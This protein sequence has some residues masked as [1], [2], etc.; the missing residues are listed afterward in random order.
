MEAVNITE[1]IDRYPLGSFQIRIILL[2]VLVALLDGFDLLAIGAAAPAMMEPLRIATN[3]IG[4][5]FS[6]ALFG[7]MLGAFVLGPV[8]DRYGRRCVLISSTAAFGV[9]TL[10]T[11]IAGTLPQ[12]LLFR[13]FAGVGLGG[14]MPS[15]IS[16]AAEYTPRSNRQAVIGLMWTGFPLGGV[17][18][19][20][21]ASRLIDAV[22]WQ[23]LF[24]IGGIL[25]VGL[26]IV[27]IRALPDSIEFL[28]M[29]RAASQKIR[30]LLVR[31]RP[32]IHIATGCQFVIDGEKTRGVPVGHLFSAGRARGTVLLWASYFLTFMILATSG[33]W[34]PTLLQRAGIPGA[35][36]SVAVALFALGSVF[37]T[38]LA[39]FL[40]SRFAARHVL[41]TALIGSA[42]TF[43]ILGHAG[44]SLALVIVCLGLAGFFLGVASSGL[45]ALGPLLYSTAIRSTGVG[46][47]MGLGRLGGIVGPLAIGLLVSR[48]WPIG[49]SFAALA[50]PALCAALFTSL[51]AI[52]RLPGPAAADHAATGTGEGL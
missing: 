47:A 44:Q 20:F 15:F 35:R 16:L 30:D 42:V 25:P 33:A 9:F 1:L 51:L 13:F 10:C 50:L 45:I 11:A 8:A 19:G 21:L 43:C 22:G 38:P 23:S 52:N 2:C 48:G 18:A 3:Q 46:W 6:A 41:P 4:L 40:V 28:V 32:T 39:G 37:G 26:S 27:L 29:R 34:T 12:V 49:D 36:S 17:I 7:L 14:A 5:L 31:I 24:Y